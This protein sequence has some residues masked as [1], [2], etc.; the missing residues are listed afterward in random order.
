[1]KVSIF[2]PTYLSWIGFYKA[3]EWADTFV[4]LDDV[5][6]E[7]HSWQIRN[8]IKTAEG[9]LVLS[10]PI[11]RNFPQDINEVKINYSTNWVKKHLQSIE[12]NYCKTPY[13]KDFSPILESVYQA[14]PEKLIT[15]NVSI[16]KGVCNFL[17]METNFRY[18]SELEV[19]N[20][21]KNEKLIAILKKLSADR[22][23]YAPGAWGY[24]EKEIHLYRENNIQLMSLTFA[25]PLYTQRHGTFIPF[26]S[27]IDMIFNCGK[28]K[29]MATL[30]NIPL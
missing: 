1:M 21:H 8:R 29:T 25:H 9:E 18:S 3:I 17:G 14:Q 2:Q 16:I 28:D 22:F 23:L 27:I 26:L 19:R 11:V 24:M 7:N 13:Y 5:Q 6:F 12:F 4:F 10:V 15:L 20:L 30:K